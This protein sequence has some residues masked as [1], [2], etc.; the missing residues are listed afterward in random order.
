MFH[1]RRVAL[2]L[3][4]VGALALTTV[5]VPAAL[6][7]DADATQASSSQQAGDDSPSTIIVQLDARDDGVERASYYAQMKT[8]IG[9]AVAATSPD[10]TIS[11]VRDYLHAFDGF[12]IQA[13]AST[14]S[15]IRS[16]AGVKGA[17]LDGNNT[18]VTDEEING[19][20]RAAGGGDTG[21]TSG[22]AA[23]MMRANAATQ[24]GQGQV[25]ELIDSGIDTSH[26][27]FAGDLDAASLR[28]TQD[29]AA[30]LISQLGAG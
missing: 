17:F 13:P 18:F 6:A 15:A 1:H 4:A 9:E 29:G 7:D 2:T 3:I 22:A 5:G 8:R 30:S 23:R 12:A 19:Q 11:D 27:A 16:T 24:K 25:I 26:E 28:L 10:A 20:Y 14:L 21:I